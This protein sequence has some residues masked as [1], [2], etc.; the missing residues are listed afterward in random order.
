MKNFGPAFLTIAC[1]FALNAQTNP[2]P[3]PVQT[4]AVAN[5]RLAEIFADSQILYLESNVGVWQGNVRGY[6]QRGNLNC[7]LLTGE[8]PQQSSNVFRNV[9]AEGKQN[10]VLIDWWDQKGQTNHAVA[11]KAV[12]TYSVTNSVTNDDV[13]LTGNP[14]VW[15]SQGTNAG[16][17]IIWHRISDTVETINSKMTIKERGTNDTDLFGAPQRPKT[18]A[19]AAKPPSEASK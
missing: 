6:E 14:V 7:D 1:A 18:N 19:P 11:D 9:V 10:R 15:S 16:D 17:K 8:W 2:P 4:N 3:L 13:I 12:Y 5:E